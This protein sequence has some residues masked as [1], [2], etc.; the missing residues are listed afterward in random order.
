MVSCASLSTTLVDWETVVSKRGVSVRANSVHEPTVENQASYTSSLARASL[1]GRFFIFFYFII[2]HERGE[3]TPYLE[4]AR[5][6]PIKKNNKKLKK[7][8]NNNNNNNDE[9]KIRYIL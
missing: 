5:R 6:S 9:K 8:N 2:V 7:T 1:C 3:D 4:H